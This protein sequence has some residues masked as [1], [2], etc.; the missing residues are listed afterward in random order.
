LI[1]T[2]GSTSE[3]Q[4]YEQIVI[5]LDR[6]T[7]VARQ[8]LYLLRRGPGKA[9]QFH[10]N[11]YADRCI[12][13]ADAGTPLFEMVGLSVPPETDE[14]Q[15]T[16]DGNRFSPIDMPFLFVRQTAGSEPFIAKLGRKWST[17]TRSQAGVPWIQPP[18][19]DR[20]AHEASKYDFEVDLETADDAAGFDLLMLPDVFDAE[21]L[22]PRSSASTS[23]GLPAARR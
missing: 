5:D 20:P 7:A 22:P 13:V 6:V 19:F 14:L 2:G 1:E 4:Y 9:F 16:G 23:S 11:S 17:E 8:G 3:P 21:D 12:F 10:V 18:P 15:S